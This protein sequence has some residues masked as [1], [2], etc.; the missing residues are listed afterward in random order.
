MQYTLTPRS[1]QQLAS[2]LLIQHL[3]LDDYGRCCPAQT[4]LS[5]LFVAC[6]RLTSLFA[7]ALW[8]RRAPSPE[9]VRQALLHN[10]PEHQLLER[11][12]NRT[13]HASLPRLR[14]PKRGQ[15]VAIDLTL[16]PYHG[17]PF[18]EA[19]ELYRGQVKSGTT[20]FHA[21]A[22]AYLVQ[23]G[24]RATLALTWVRHK[25]S[26]TAVLKRLLGWVSRA[27][28]RPRLL[29]LDRGFYAVDVI[30]YLQAARRPFL[31]PVPLKGRKEDH[32]RGPGGTRVFATWRRSGLGVYRLH[33]TGGRTA[34]VRICVHCRNRRGRRGK[35]GRER[36]VY[37][38]WGWQPPAPAQVS[39]LYRERFGVETSY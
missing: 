12:F 2:Q 11:R 29:L 21:Y 15:R 34:A 22:T 1:V 3:A 39:L 31:M 17:R 7:A 19:N 14:R 38:F 5:I 37:A 6:Q 8:L 28:V 10:L 35:R 18:R 24:Q 25:E 20:H 16:L 30:R 27:G 33:P 9:T 32:P 4:L 13:L 23:K 26:L 36:L